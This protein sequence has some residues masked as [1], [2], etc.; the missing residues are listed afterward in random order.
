FLQKNRKRDG[1][2]ARA[3]SGRVRDMDGVDIV[4]LEILC[5]VNGLA[6]IVSHWRN[7]LD[8]LDVFVMRELMSKFRTFVERK[9]RGRKARVDGHA[10]RH[11]LY[12]RVPQ[13]RAHSPAYRLDMVWRC[14]A[15]SAHNAYAILHKLLRI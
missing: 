13:H 6:V 14:A 11:G 1:V 5:L 10:R 12:A 3:R 15:T 9:G 4:G 2:H 7:H 8:D